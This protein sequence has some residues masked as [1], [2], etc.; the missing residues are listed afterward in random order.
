MIIETTD[1]KR[2]EFKHVK[3]AQCPRCHAYYETERL[4]DGERFAAPCNHP[5]SEKPPNVVE[6]DPIKPEG[7][8]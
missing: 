2:I 1:G 8:A 3:R 4:E 7:R 6:A 5:L